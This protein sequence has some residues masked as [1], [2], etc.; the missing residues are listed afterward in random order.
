[1]DIFQKYFQRNL[2]IS[3]QFFL[4]LKRISENWFEKFGHKYRALNHTISINYKT[5]L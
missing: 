3:K 2:E 5:V 1:M 4:T